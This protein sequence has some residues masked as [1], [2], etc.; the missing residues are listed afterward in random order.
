MTST[1]KI[2]WWAKTDRPKKYGND[3]VTLEGDDLTESEADDIL[4][5]AANFNKGRVALPKFEALWN[6]ATFC[7]DYGVVK[8]KQVKEKEASK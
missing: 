8:V 6:C 7:L 5:D 2:Y 1:W 3:V 4:G